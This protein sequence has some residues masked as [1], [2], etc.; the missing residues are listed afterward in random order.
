M[1]Q[2]QHGR[3]IFDENA[4]NGL[5][6]AF[7]YR[8]RKPGAALAVFRMNTELYP[9]SWN[10]WDSLAEAYQF[11][12]QP[13]KAETCWLK[14]RDLAPENDH[15][16]QSLTRIRGV[17]QDYERETAAE[18]ATTPGRKTGL[19]GPYLG[20]NP[21][22]RTPK[23]FAP[24]IISSHDNFEFSGTFS[25]DG[26]EFY[27]TRRAHGARNNVIMV[28]RQNNGEWL[29]PEPASFSGRYSDHEPHITPDGGRLYFGGN[30]PQAEGA[31]PEYGIFYV[32][33]EGGDWGEPVY[34]GPGMYVSVSEKGNMYLTDVGIDA[35]GGI[36]RIPLIDGKRGEPIRLGGG[37]NEPT[38]AAHAFV[39][40]DE[41][42]VI[43][44]A[45]RPAGQGGE[46]DYYV[47]F[48]QPDGSWGPAIN[49]GDE[50]NSPGANLCPFLSHDGKYLFYTA[51]R[52]IYWVSAA[53]LEDLRPGN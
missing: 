29:A 8:E 42:F 24:G 2:D 52:D 22:G 53:I 45:T 7:L 11:A 3:F 9:G 32:E 20:Q 19:K 36:L 38:P 1:R 44:D 27:F 51:Y 39:A 41:R 5:G 14:A 49:L 18:V 43:F 40:R 37:V 31:A 15:V 33:R 34:D 10:T 17:L 28:C 35:G 50:I 16:K 47:S 4:F 48:R 25:P 12:G 13:R 21:P 26:R 23:V 6:Y 46:G 30:R